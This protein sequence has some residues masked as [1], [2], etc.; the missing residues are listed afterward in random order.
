MWIQVAS[1]IELLLSD[2]SPT[3]IAL[4]LSSYYVK[5]HYA[6]RLPSKS[7]A[8]VSLAKIFC[9][10][11]RSLAGLDRSDTS[12]PRAAGGFR[13]RPRRSPAP[14]LPLRSHH[15]QLVAV[16]GHAVRDPGDHNLGA[17]RA[18]SKVVLVGK[19]ICFSADS[20]TSKFLTSQK[21]Q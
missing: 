14:A 18:C 16:L 11:A 21:L 5:I 10:S 6:S 17:F 15:P 3:H 9:F 1:G 4:Q 13:A 19:S 7:N 8:A 12:L 20:S 2:I